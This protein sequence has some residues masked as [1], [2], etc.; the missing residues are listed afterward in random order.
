MAFDVAEIYSR[1]VTLHQIDLSLFDQKLDAKTKLLSSLHK[2]L[3]FSRNTWNLLFLIAGLDSAYSKL[4]Y[5]YKN[6]YRRKK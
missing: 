1:K 3:Y 5:A 4:Q 2:N 6:V